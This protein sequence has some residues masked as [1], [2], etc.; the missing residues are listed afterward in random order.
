MRIARRK[1]D[2]FISRINEKFKIRGIAFFLGQN[3][4]WVELHL[5]EIVQKNVEIG[6]PEK[7]YGG[8]DVEMFNPYLNKKEIDFENRIRF[9]TERVMGLMGDMGESEDEVS[10]EEDFSLG[11]DFSLNAI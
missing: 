6:K 4:H 2:L 9:K 11:D 5:L 10:L 8:K 7:F 3:L 1:A